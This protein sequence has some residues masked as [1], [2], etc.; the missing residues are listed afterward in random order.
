MVIEPHSIRI[1]KSIE[2]RKGNLR[3]GECTHVSR[4]TKQQS[5]SIK[6]RR[7]RSRQI[8]R[9]VD[10]G[11]RE[12]TAGLFKDWLSWCGGGRDQFS[13]GCEITPGYR[14]LRIAL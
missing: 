3:R 13:Q 11:L 9:T 2:G 6:G 8:V 7:Q 12:C 1:R 10:I 14:I 4:T 5:A